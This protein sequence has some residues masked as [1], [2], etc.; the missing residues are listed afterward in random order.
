MSEELGE[1]I[2]LAKEDL[3]AVSGGGQYTWTKDSDGN[4]ICP[5]CG[6]TNVHGVSQAHMDMYQ[7][8]WDCGF[9]FWAESSGNAEPLPG[10]YNYEP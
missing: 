6:G 2:Q 7:D 5:V 9:R 3:D 8:C 4:M 10:Y 1:R